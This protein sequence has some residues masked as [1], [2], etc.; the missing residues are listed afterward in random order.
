MLVEIRRYTIKS[1]RRDEFVRFF[2]DEVQPAMES[3]GMRILETYVGAEDNQTFVYLRS[4]ETAADR[5]RQLHDF[6]EGREW[7]DGLRDRA[8]AMEEAFHV[9]LVVP[10]APDPAC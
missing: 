6:Y 4:F 5:T 7:L 2:H 8:L 3:V 1:G 10:A 9:D